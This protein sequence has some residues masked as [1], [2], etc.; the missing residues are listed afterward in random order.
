MDW[1]AFMSDAMHGVVSVGVIVITGL[2]YRY[3]GYQ[4]TAA[5][6][7][8]VIDKATQLANQAVAAAAPGFEQAVIHITDPIVQNAVPK[9]VDDLKNH[10]IEITPA[11]AADKIQ[12]ALGAAQVSSGTVTPVSTLLVK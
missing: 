4:V 12:A 10:G 6:Q 7:T 9:M 2:V 3:T 8:M 1:N 5:Q 11:K